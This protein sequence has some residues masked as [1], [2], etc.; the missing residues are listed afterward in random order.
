MLGN[1]DELSIRCYGRKRDMRGELVAIEID[2]QV[3]FDIRRVFYIYDVPVGIIRGNHG[4]YRCR[5]LLI[6]QTGRIKIEATDG[7][8]SRILELGAA[9]GILVNPGIFISFTHLE[10]G[11]ILLALVDSPYD[12]EDFI[13]ELEEVRRF[14]RSA[15]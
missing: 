6:C 15:S 11:S 9:E 13:R 12:P 3:P 5:Q 2:G 10:P 1:L 14:R 4:H 8:K 7:E